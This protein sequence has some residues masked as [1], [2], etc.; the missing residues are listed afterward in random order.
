M[1]VSLSASMRG[2]LY[3]L[4]DLTDQISTANQRL[5]TGKK[6]NSAID[7]ASAFFSAKAFSQESDKLNGLLNGLTQGRQTI[8][9]VNKAIDGA[10]KLL[11]SADGLAKTAQLSSSDTDRAALRDQVAELLT[12]SVRLLA[13]SGF[14]GKQVLITDSTT[15][16]AASYAIKATAAGLGAGTAAEKAVYNGGLLTIATN[17]QTT[18]F[19][20]IVINPI[21]VRFSTTIAN[22]GLGLTRLAAAAGTDNG[23]LIAAPAANVPVTIGA[24]TGAAWDVAN[25]QTQITNFRT[26]IANAINNL[27]AKSA[28]VATQAAAIDIRVSYTTDSS[29]IYSKAADDLTLADINQEGANLSSLQTKQQLSVQALSLAS[30]ADQAILRL[31]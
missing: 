15:L 10:I 5:A 21:D 13:D 26:D 18:N 20:A 16:T 29:R 25:N 2:A 19:T 9:R 6:V 12:Q 23:F 31:F 22:G 14:N 11:Q 28:A 27:Q 17:T 3:S 7:N 8:D 30:R 24:T 1:S 4:N